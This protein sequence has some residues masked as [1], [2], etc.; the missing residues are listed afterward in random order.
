MAR[1]NV[2]DRSGLTL[3]E[4]M[5]A[6]ALFAVVV[7]ITA[8]ALTSFYVSMDIQ[9]QRI[10]ALQSCRAVMGALREKRAEFLSA[11]GEF[12]REA[13][14]AWITQRNNDSWAEFLKNSGDHIELA[15]QSL[16]VQCFNMDGAVATALDDPIEAHV[17]STWNDR[18]GRLMRAEIVSLLAAR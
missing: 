3:M 5:M 16:N 1:R 11:Q 4:V 14:L 15:D 7:G 18:K 2:C 17:I 9:E 12:D 8:T 6:V 10:E 13:F